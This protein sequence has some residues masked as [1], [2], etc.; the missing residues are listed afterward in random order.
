MAW[1]TKASI[2][3]L[4]SNEAATEEA[5]R[6]EANTIFTATFIGMVVDRARRGYRVDMEPD[7]DE[8]DEAARTRKDRAAMQKHNDVCAKVNHIVRSFRPL[9]EDERGIHWGLTPEFS[10][11]GLISGGEA[12]LKDYA[13]YDKR[14]MET[15]WNYLTQDKVGQTP[16][17]YIGRGA[18]CGLV[19]ADG[20]VVTAMSTLRT[21]LV[22]DSPQEYSIDAGD[23]WLPP[24]DSGVYTGR[25]TD[26]ESGYQS[27]DD[28]FA[29]GMIG[30]CKRSFGQQQL[31]HSNEGMKFVPRDTPP[32]LDDKIVGYTHGLVRA[33]YECERIGEGRPYEMSLGT[34]TA[35]L[36]SCMSC[37]FFM[38]AN[39]YSPSASHLGAGESWLPLYHASQH[40]FAPH[41]KPSAKTADVEQKVLGAI[42][43]A[44]EAMS[45]AENNKFQQ[46]TK[47]LESASGDPDVK[48][49]LKKVA[50]KVTKKV[51]NAAHA[52]AE[53]QN[54]AVAW[55]PS[56][57]HEATLKADLIQA[58]RECNDRWAWK[59][60]AWMTTG[61]QAMQ[62]Q[63][64][65][66]ADTPTLA[67]LA[68]RLKSIT[69]KE[70]PAACANLYLDAMTCHAKDLDRLDKALK[71]GASPQPG[72][73]HKDDH[74][75]ADWLVGE[76]RSHPWM[77]YG[78]RQFRSPFSS[79]YIAEFR[80]LPTRLQE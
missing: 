67:R 22:A 57:A 11:G 51:P 72:S 73:E 19:V 66:V 44:K 42:G 52:T 26:P 12:A 20:N 77:K 9:L 15:A 17:V 64:D 79:D 3:G 55:A 35:K 6:S 4:L 41:Y 2:L 71:F 28:D 14:F 25:L 49:V 62:A 39:G 1:N 75:L 27:L 30:D 10:R 38:V 40:Q 63:L 80:R 7:M 33:I 24:K 23:R 36:A 16:S 31:N 48:K 59:M 60:A 45:K 70:N 5:V 76:W 18:Y 29:W 68:E 37:S 69:L 50:Q 78:W 74:A 46:F 13:G 8:K 58:M 61:V 54:K 32:K 65:W 56:A 34:N 47:A 43:A 53:E 21:V